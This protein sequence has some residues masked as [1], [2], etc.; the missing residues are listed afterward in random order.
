MNYWIYLETK[1]LP[2]CLSTFGIKYGWLSLVGRLDIATKILR[3]CIVTI[4]YFIITINILFKL[5]KLRL[6]FVSH[7]PKSFNLFTFVF[8][9][10]L[11]HKLCVLLK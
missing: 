6:I 7:F 2:F 1:L 11:Q 4:V 8:L 5:K 10:R 9:L 3:K